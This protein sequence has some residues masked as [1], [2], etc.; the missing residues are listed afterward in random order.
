MPRRIRMNHEIGFEIAKSTPPVAVSTVA[1]L[2]GWDMDAVIGGLTVLYLVLQI[3][4][5]IS[6][7]R[8]KDKQ[9]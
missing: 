3:A 6:K 5:L 2:Q 4:Y 9:P 8:S 7:W 1:F